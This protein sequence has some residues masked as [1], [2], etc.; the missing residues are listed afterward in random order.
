M[1]KNIHMFSFKYYCKLFYKNTYNIEYLIKYFY[2]L[3]SL[4]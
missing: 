2:K 3:F 1:R 4:H